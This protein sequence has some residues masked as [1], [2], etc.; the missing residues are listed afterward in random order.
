MTQKSDVACK[1][2]RWGS[3]ENSK[4]RLSLSSEP[5]E[6]VKEGRIFEES[7]AVHGNAGPS[8]NQKLAKPFNEPYRTVWSGY[9]WVLW[10]V[11]RYI[12][13][14]MVVRGTAIK[15]R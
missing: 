9:Y 10:L 12:R 14:C 11:N 6:S 8:D 13:S 7:F 1:A 5:D 3:F 15:W 4:G 2:L